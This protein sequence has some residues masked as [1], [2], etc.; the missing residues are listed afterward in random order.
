LKALQIDFAPRQRWYEAGTDKRH[1]LLWAGV[2]V[3]MLLLLGASVA[4]AWKLSHERSAV[5]A[6][7]TT[8]RAALEAGQESAARSDDLSAEAAESVQQ[9]NQHLNYPWA[10]M[11]GI[12]ERNAQP[13]VTLMSVEMGVVRQS[14]KLV[15]EAADVGAALSYVENLRKQPA[16]ASLMVVRQEKTGTDGAQ[17][18]RFTLEAPVAQAPEPVTTRADA[19]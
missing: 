18:M 7:V 19:R 10:N 12:L 6:R 2:C 13:Q 9:A 16:Y 8:L 11:L 3:V 1:R 14:N 17:G 5:S 4:T 15:I